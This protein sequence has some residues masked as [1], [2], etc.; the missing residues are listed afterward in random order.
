MIVL[1]INC[2]DNVFAVEDPKT[3]R[4]GYC[5]LMEKLGEV[6]GIGVYLGNDKLT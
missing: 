1:C 6:F 5:C 4:I 3:T 2:I